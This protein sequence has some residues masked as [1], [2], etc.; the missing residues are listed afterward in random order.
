MLSCSDRFVQIAKHIAVP[1]L[2]LLALAQV[3]MAV[4]LIKLTLDFGSLDVSKSATFIS[5]ALVYI[6]FARAIDQRSSRSPGKFLRLMAW[7]ITVMM[8]LQTV[9]SF[10]SLEIK[11]DWARYVL[12]SGHAV[13]AMGCAVV[14]ASDPGFRT[15]PL[16]EE[17]PSTL[18]L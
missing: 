9:I 4:G 2:V 16:Y 13:A 14:A 6:G 18:G 3:A 17:V 1:M 10:S 8:I 11:H 5:A 15:R 7:L 12:G